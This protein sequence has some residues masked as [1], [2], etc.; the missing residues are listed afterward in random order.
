MGLF[1]SI[2]E[3]SLTPVKDDWRKKLTQT[4][5][6]AT[7]SKKANLKSVPPKKNERSF[8]NETLDYITKKFNSSINME[9]VE[10]DRNFDNLQPNKKASVQGIC[11]Q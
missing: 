2:T 6:P 11:S 5:K 1:H 8:S 4:P 9:E 10:N 3:K 7:V